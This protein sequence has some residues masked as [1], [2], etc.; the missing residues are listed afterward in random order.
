MN[1]ITLYNISIYT[2]NYSEFTRRI[3]VVG[4]ASLIHFQN[5]VYQHKLVVCNVFVI[6]FHLNVLWNSEYAVVAPMVIYRE[7]K[8]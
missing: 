8:D 1:I 7:I 3:S 5:L 4:I 6:L 2:R